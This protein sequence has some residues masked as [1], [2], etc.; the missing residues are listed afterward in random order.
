MEGISLRPAFQGQPLQ[1][2]QPLFFEHEGNRAVRD[3]PWKLVRLPNRPWELYNLEEDR[4][5]LRDLA[6]SQPERVK[7]MKAQWQ[8]WAERADVVPGPF[9]K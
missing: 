5:E 2:E 6:E 9:A 4:T 8:S 3:G 7:E 1:R